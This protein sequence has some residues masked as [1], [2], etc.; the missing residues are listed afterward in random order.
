MKPGEL[1]DI[2]VMGA[3]FVL[4]FCSWCICVVLWVGQY[5]TRLKKVQ[6]RL[7]ITDRDTSESQVLRLW[8]EAYEDLKRSKSRKR[9]TFKDRLE[10]LRSDA[11]WQGPAH[12]VMLGVAGVACL[13]F[14]AT[15]MVGGGI[16]LGSASAAAV[17]VIFWVYTQRRIGKRAVLFERQLVDALGIAARALRA[18]HPLVGA[19]Q[20]VSEETADPVGPIFYQMCQEQALGLSL[21]DSIRK[22]AKNT[23][24]PELKLFA[25]AVAIQLKSGGNLA[26]LM[27]S[28]AAVMRSRTRLNRRVRVITA[29]TQLSKKILIAIPILLFFALNVLTPQ[30]MHVFYDTWPGRFMLT[31]AAVSVLFGSWMMGRLSVLRY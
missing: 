29:Q 22:V 1:T 31:A 8:R 9:T 14:L 4:V 18:G 6:K 27:D 16:M 11:G 21:K 26:D 12:T 10:R 17:V 19:F 3:V 28:L 5:I 20:L 30:Y 23:Y 7:D 25:T 13:A 2:I 15:Y 24:N